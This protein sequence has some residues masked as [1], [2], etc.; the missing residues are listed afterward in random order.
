MGIFSC[1]HSVQT[2]RVE[3]GIGYKISEVCDKLEAYLIPH[4][5]SLCNMCNK[6]NIIKIHK[7]VRCE[8]LDIPRS[9]LR[10]YN[11]GLDNLIG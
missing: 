7:E 3:N 10:R 8:D 5:I 6:T 1:N 11:L 2:T 4:D 9:N